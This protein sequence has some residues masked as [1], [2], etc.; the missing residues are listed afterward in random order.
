VQAVTQ[1]N[2]SCTPAPLKCRKLLLVWTVQPCAAKYALTSIPW[3]WDP[4][5]FLPSNF[6]STYPFLILPLNPLFRAFEGPIFWREENY[7]V[8]HSS[9]H[10]VEDKATHYL[11]PTHKH[12]FRTQLW[13]PICLFSDFLLGS[14]F[15]P[16]NPLFRS[17]PFLCCLFSCIFALVLSCLLEFG[18]GWHD[19]FLF[20]LRINTFKKPNFW[21]SKKVIQ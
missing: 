21:S 15:S 11:S 6:L 1:V 18:E 14:D 13:V 9:S 2:K 16:W 7:S 17:T 10:L 3:L 4:A 20:F 5:D 12:T 19:P 8:R